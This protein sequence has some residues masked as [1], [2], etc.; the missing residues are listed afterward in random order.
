MNVNYFN[1]HVPM[2]YGNIENDNNSSIENTF[3]MSDEYM[4]EEVEKIM[5]KSLLRE[6]I[7]QDVDIDN[8]NLIPKPEEIVKINRCF[9]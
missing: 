4:N 2:V 6:N 3:I 7:P 8:N 9:F 5:Y 1:E